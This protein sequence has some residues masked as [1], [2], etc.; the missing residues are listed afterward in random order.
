MR[1]TTGGAPKARALG[2][3]LREA[4]EATGRSMRA[5][6]RDLETNHVKLQ[7]YETGEIVPKPELVATY[8]TA[9][10]VSAAER[11]RLVEMARDADQ[12]DWLSTTKSGS[13]KELTM[14]VEFERTATNISDIATGVIP[15]LLQTA[16]YAR[17][18]MH[19]LPLNEVE[20][21]VLMRVGRREILAKK[22]APRFTAIL[23]ESALWELIGGREV[24]VEQLEHVIHMSERPNVDVRVVRSG[25]TR[26]HPAHMGSFTVYEFAKANPIVH[27]E[28][29]RSSASLTNSGIANEYLNA[30]QDL[31][32]IAMS[33]EQSIEFI[34][35]RIDNLKE[36]R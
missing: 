30:V 4:R 9:L 23:A 12:E 11:D 3:E 1:R 7:R 26:W 19:G 35:E 28:H 6:A 20:T 29:Y 33:T 2:A 21:L 31:T 5:L 32:N 15:G 27:M 17:A 14:L 22:N 10:G 36:A 25:A 16:D 8:L 34:A 24:M 13:R 18:I